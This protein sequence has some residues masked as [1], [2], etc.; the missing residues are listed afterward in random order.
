MTI[1]IIGAGQAGLLAARSLQNYHPTI[2][3][4]QPSLPNNHSALLRFRSNIVGATIGVDFKEVNV[5]KGVLCDD[6]HTINNS[7]TLRDFNAYSF[8]TT[9]KVLERSIIN[10]SNARRYIAPPNFIGLLA[11]RTTIQYSISAE[12]V[13]SEP[14][15]N[16]TIISTIPM[17]MLMNI[18]KYPNKPNCESL[19]IW[20]INCELSN[21]NIY[22]TLYVPYNEC[23]PYRISITGNI[24][25]MEF[26]AEPNGKDF[27]EKYL[28]ILNIPVNY[29]NFQAKQQTYGKIIPIDE[30]ER[31]KF[32]LWAT[33]RYN[34]YSLGRY[35]TWRQILLDDV[36]KDIQ[37]IKRFLEQRG[38]YQ[39]A[40][41]YNNGE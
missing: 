28:D 18:L 21:T 6:G 31:Q 22:Q 11:N 5:Y 36:T 12:S 19:S 16:S 10:T 1:T 8:K 32:I 24:M 37:I 14:S 35:A 27:I 38:N 7:P 15:R 13:L 23:E 41:H 39:R 26:S 33:D 29:S 25:T 17:P 20:T 34:I 40:M 3:E 30:Y 9:G 2:I 4:Q